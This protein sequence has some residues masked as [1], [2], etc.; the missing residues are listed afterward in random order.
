MDEGGAIKTAE[1][2]PETGF[3]SVLIA[4]TWSVIEKAEEGTVQKI[5]PGQLPRS[6]ESHVYE[7]YHSL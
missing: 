2:S 1:L 6:M 4:F 5:G 3:L 7:M